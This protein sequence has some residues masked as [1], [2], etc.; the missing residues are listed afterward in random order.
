MESGSRNI[1]DAYRKKVS[2]MQGLL[3]C[4]NLEKESLVTLDV[5]SLWSLMKEKD[6]L[7]ASIGRTNQEIR[8]AETQGVDGADSPK[9]FGQS[10]KGLSREIRRLKKEIGARVGENLSF[11]QEMLHFFDEIVSM[12]AAGSQAEP[13]YVSP[14]KRARMSHSM[15]YKR[16][17]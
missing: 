1:E 16:E 3:G 12:L 2:L 11:T 5:K 9:G 15:I 7:L 13:A 10:V 14:L 17:V 4:L 6:D 8:A